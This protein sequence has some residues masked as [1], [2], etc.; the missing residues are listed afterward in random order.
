MKE[1]GFYICEE[2]NVFDELSSLYED[3]KPCPYA[4]ALE[5]D[6]ALAWE[7][8][9]LYTEF[10]V[11]DNPELAEDYGMDQVDFQCGDILIADLF[12]YGSRINL[13]HIRRPLVVV[14][15]NA[16]RVYGIQLTTGHPASLTNYL[17]EVPNH[18]DC[19][20]RY[21]SSFNL[22]S[23]VSV[24]RFR[25]VHR[26]GHIT[27]EQRQAILDK[28][29]ELKSNLSE[30]DTYGWWTTEKIDQTITN[31]ERISC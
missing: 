3:L 10:V 2:D 1:T 30:L 17:V 16:F 21:P 27:Q 8:D 28:L 9:N 4:D 25:L 15:A 23:I 12:Q 13:D 19:N 20:L 26:I 31:L 24:E 14:Y 11:E 29:T 5:M 6:S 18:T 22:A 7:E